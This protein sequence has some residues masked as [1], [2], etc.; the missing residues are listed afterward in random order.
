MH[1]QRF[2]WIVTAAAWALIG[3]GSLVTTTGSGLSIPDWPLAFGRPVPPYW[4]GGVVFE[5]THRVVAGA[6]FVL[7]TV[8]LV[9]VWRTVSTR[10]VRYWA[11]GTWGLLVMQAGLGGVT[12]LHELP[13]PVSVAHAGLAQAT[14]AAMVALAVKLTPVTSAGETAVS[15]GR[16]G[17]LFPWAFGLVG[18]L[19]LQVLI[20]A[21]VR[22]MGAGLAVP[23]FPLA[24]G[25]LWPP[26]EWFRVP[27]L[28]PKIWVH[29]IH[30][31]G[32]LLVGVV[33]YAVGIPAVRRFR[34]VRAV[35]GAA[36]VL[37]YGWAL[38]IVFGGWLIWGTRHWLPT[39]LHV[40]TGALLLGAGTFLALRLRGVEKGC[41]S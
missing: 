12:V 20:G 29:M 38:Q 41:R 40:M 30:R 8:L 2:A 15:V 31:V 27:Y 4:E 9:R 1:L 25:H 34:D 28:A 39:T 36:R 11:L 16:R 24:Y 3:V 18:V 32:A 21:L 19:Y 14:L 17:P 23:D 10:S 13:R 35:A 5:Y 6:V 26:A 22:H 33:V 37:M 7:M